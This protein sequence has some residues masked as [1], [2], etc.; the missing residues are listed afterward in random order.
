[1]ESINEYLILPISIVYRKSFSYLSRYLNDEINPDVNKQRYYER[2]SSL[3]QIISFFKESNH[4]I[5]NIYL[6][7]ARNS[8][9][10]ESLKDN[11]IKLIINVTKEIPNYYPDEFKYI[12]YYINDDNKDTIAPFLEESYQ[13]IIDYQKNNDGNILVHCYMGASRSV[14]IIIYYLMR[15]Y[16]NKFD[17]KNS[18]KFIKNKRSIIN[19]TCKLLDDIQKQINLNN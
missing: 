16:N 10:Y 17:I 5:D 9:S 12:N 1:M 18:I 11:N 8:G 7:N 14:S 2:I 15:K 19:P 6:G 13:K 4:I 3:K